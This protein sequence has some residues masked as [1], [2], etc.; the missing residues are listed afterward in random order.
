M[1]L[2]AK[3]SSR[4]GRSAEVVTPL[5]GARLTLILLLSLNLLNFMDRYVLAAVE[6]EIRTELLLSQDPEDKSAKFKTGLLSTAFFVTYSIIAPVF[7]WLAER[8]SR[9]KLIGIGVIVW[10]LASGASGLPWSLGISNSYLLQFGITEAFFLLFLTRCFVGVGEGAYG[11]IAPTVISDLYPERIRGR[12]LAWFYMAIP[13]GS[14][15]GFALGGQVKTLAP[16]NILGRLTEGWRLAFYMV[17][18]PGIILG[19]LCF[20]MR[21]PERGRADAATIR[22]GRRL[23]RRDYLALLRIPSYTLDTLGMAAMTF[24][25]GGLAYWMPEYLKSEKAESFGSIEPI[26]IFGGLTV[27][28]GL[29]ATLA[30]GIAGDKLRSRIPGS[31]F[32]V[33]GI[34]M[35]LGFIF[36]IMVL[37]T[38]FPT[39]WYFVFITL[40][41]IFFNTG[42]TNTILANVTHPAV[43]AS[44]FAFNIFFIH[45]FGDIIS[46][47]TIGYIADKTNLK[48]GFFVISLMM[49]VSGIVWLCGTRFLQ[50]DTEAAPARLDLS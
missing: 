37:W 20:F 38:P 39:A 2:A 26:T 1:D 47:P 11:P 4:V 24:A 8:N 7:G 46:P 42:P 28:T 40:F 36:F 35:I 22:S 3:P 49:L 13:V 41:C 16:V 17:V 30:G 23:T 48:V 34:T 15:L 45:A 19:L 10:S 21:D 5:P 9:W 44:G 25:T 14:A 27:I 32:L 29:T 31:Y 6:P 50:W 18:I 43:R 33:S 12:V